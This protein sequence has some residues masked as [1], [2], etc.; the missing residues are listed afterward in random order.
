[1]NIITEHKLLEVKVTLKHAY[2]LLT[3]M[4]LQGAIRSDYVSSTN[5]I[6]KEL[7]EAM[8]QPSF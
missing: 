6:L 3:E 1:M 5:D 8:K 2:D 4:S 7:Y